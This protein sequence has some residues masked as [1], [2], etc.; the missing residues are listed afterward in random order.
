MVQGRDLWVLSTSKV[1]ALGRWWGRG[2][3]EAEVCGREREEAYGRTQEYN[4]SFAFIGAGE[5]VGFLMGWVGCEKTGP[6]TL[7]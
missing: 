3:C 1:R 2:W 6:H 5:A 4:L 7:R